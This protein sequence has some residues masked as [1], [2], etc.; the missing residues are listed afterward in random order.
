MTI[1]DLAVW[2]PASVIKPNAVA[3]MTNRS[4]SS[5]MYVLTDAARYSSSRISLHS[6]VA[7]RVIRVRSFAVKDDDTSTGC[8]LNFATVDRQDRILVSDSESGYVSAYDIEGRRLMTF[9]YVNG[10][11]NASAAAAPG[12]NVGGCGR[13]RMLPQGL[14]VDAANNILVA[15]QSD[16]CGD[17]GKQQDGPAAEAMGR[18]LKFSPDGQF[19]EV[20]HSWK[21]SDYGRP[22]GLAYDVD[23]RMLAVTT[24]A[25]VRVY[26]L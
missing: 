19:I 17:D 10:D 3:V 25:R 24:D 23:G 11:G 26:R 16:C 7:G 12:S 14:A 15:D 6:P 8:G 1:R 5:S 22:W 21:A 13:R 9:S 2:R 18:V 4:N 20:V